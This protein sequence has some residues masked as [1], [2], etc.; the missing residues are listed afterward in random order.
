MLIV[1]T[2]APFTW[3]LRTVLAHVMPSGGGIHRISSTRVVRL[4]MTAPGVGP[5]TALAVAAAFDDAAGFRRTSGVGAYLGLT[6]EA[7][8]VGRSQ[9]QWPRREATR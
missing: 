2:D 9:R 3:F 5:V 8:Q 4:F 7:P 6:R 1:V